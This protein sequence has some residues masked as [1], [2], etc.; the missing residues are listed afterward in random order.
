[1][2]RDFNNYKVRNNKASKRPSRMIFLDV[3]TKHIDEDNVQHHYMDYGWVNYIERSKDKSLKCD[4]WS[5]Y[6]D[7]VKMWDFIESKSY[8]KSTLYIFGHNIYFD[9][10]SSGFFRIFTDNGW[11]LVFMYDKGLTFIMSIKKDN[12]SIKIISSTNFYDTSLAKVGDAL[13]IP[14]MKVNFEEDTLEY[15][16]EYCKNDV[17][18]C[19]EAILKYLDF[20]DDNDMGNFGMT[21]ATQ[22]FNCYRH[23]FMHHQLY[24]HSEED[25]VD[26]ERRSYIGGRNECFELGE[27]EDGPFLHYDINSMYPFVM[28]NNKFPTRLVDTVTDIDIDK[29]HKL[30]SSF[31]AIAEVDIDTNEPAYGCVRNGKVVFPRGRISVVLPTGSLLYAIENNHIKRIHRVAL[32]E[33]DYIFEDYIDYFYPLKRQYKTDGNKIYER[34]VKIFLNSLYGKFGQK[35]AIEEYEYDDNNYG[36]Y[37]IE[38]YDDITNEHWIETELLHTKI[39]GVGEESSPTSLVAIPSHVTDYARLVLWSIIKDVGIKNMLYCDTDSIKIRSK[40]KDLVKYPIDNFELGKLSL[41]DTTNTF[42]IYGCKDYETEHSLKIKGVPKN[43]IKVGDNSYEYSSFPRMNTHLRKQ[44]SDHYIINKIVKT[45]KR[46]YDKGFV[47]SSHKVHP[48]ILNEW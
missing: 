39:I 21:K 27:L 3:E 2:V 12:R 18:I 36:Y 26:M 31:C 10:Q 5:F 1:M 45:N 38:C 41:E 13:G 14:K 25:I 20:I 30:L 34:I 6:N 35:N 28:K 22:A 8:G 19:R 42:N 46:V 4:T 32:Y 44:I 11:K 15:K 16:I 9:L 37:R 43:A 23:R 17:F 24:V 47:D 29:L 33:S 40:H 7:N 48:F